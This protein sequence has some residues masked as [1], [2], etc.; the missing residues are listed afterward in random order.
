[1][2]RDRFTPSVLGGGP[3]R[4][5]RRLRP[6]IE[7]LPGDALD[8]RDHAPS[9]VARARQF[10]TH[11]AFEEHRTAAAVAGAVEAMI[12]AQ[13]PVDLVALASGFLIDEMAHVEL[14][15][16]VA[17]ALGG[18]AELTHDAGALYPRPAA[19]RPPLLA[20]A[21]RVLRVFCVGEAYS[22]PMQQANARAA[23][24]PLIRAVLARIARDEAPHAAFGWTFFD[25]AD[26]QLDEPA[27]VHLRQIAASSVEQLARKLDAAA[28]DGDETLGWLAPDTHRAA[29][30]QALEQSVR[31]PLAARGLL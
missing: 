9:L 4:R 31:A 14:C 20:A 16:R 23:R 6:D 28:G 19:D 1:M 22:L 18:G 17:A 11:T 10:W 8:P 2:E 7:R 24:H 30:K 21:E 5:Y 26:E 29:A 3:E 27:R 13:T 12:A 25:W 15:A